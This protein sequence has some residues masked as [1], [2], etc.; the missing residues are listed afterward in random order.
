MTPQMLY[1]GFPLISPF[2]A[3]N[4]SGEGW[5]A[6]SSLSV[7]PA[8]TP[9]TSCRFTFS[10]TRVGWSSSYPPVLGEVR[11]YDE[12]GDFADIISSAS[13]PGSWLPSDH[14]PNKVHDGQHDECLHDAFL[15]PM[16]LVVTFSSASTFAA[17][18]L[19]T[20]ESSSCKTGGEVTS[21]TL[22]C[23]ESESGAPWAL[24]DE[25]VDVT[26]PPTS[27][28]GASGGRKRYG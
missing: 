19:W 7:Q 2:P 13:S 24:V 27:S 11:F 9:V 17:Y 23:R 1:G 15:L 5:V 6:Q 25:R 20:G 14:G 22:H 12:Q 26:P 21:W 8:T 28:N 16:T 3:T 10:D 4:A 18:D